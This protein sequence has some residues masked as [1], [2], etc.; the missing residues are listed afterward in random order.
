MRFHTLELLYVALMLSLPI[1]PNYGQGSP[2]SDPFME[3]GT[4]RRV[5]TNITIHTNDPRPLA[6]AVVTIR[7]EFG[8]M[9]DYEDPVYAT[10]D[11]VDARTPAFL[12]LHPAAHSMLRSRGGDFSHT[13]SSALS[14]DAFV[15]ELVSAHASSQNPGHF[16]V[17][18]SSA[19]RLAIVGRTPGAI[20]PLDTTITLPPASTNGLEALSRVFETVKALT[21]NQIGIGF[22]NPGNFVRCNVSRGYNNA[23]AR[24]AIIAILDDCHQA[25]TYQLLFDV[26]HN[27][28]VISFDA[29]MRTETDVSGKRWLRPVSVP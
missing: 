2:S 9:L 17:V 3:F 19:N 27:K 11:L 21:G 25:S 12:A 14:R 16:E 15:A 18:S 24:Q 4:L 29:L 7:R 22:L 23:S 28:Y 1:A 5:G 10:T 6:Q 13:F 20:S 8:W 26:N